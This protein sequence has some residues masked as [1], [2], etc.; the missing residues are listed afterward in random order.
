MLPT[1][2]SPSGSSARQHLSI[3]KL[4]VTM[5]RMELSIFDLLLSSSLVTEMVTTVVEVEVELTTLELE[6]TFEEMRSMKKELL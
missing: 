5:T 1:R 4:K 3:R 2:F 6:L